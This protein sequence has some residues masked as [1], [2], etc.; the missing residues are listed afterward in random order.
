ML[1]E[2]KQAKSSRAA[3]LQA[4]YNKRTE[5]RAEALD[6]E[7]DFDALLRVEVEQL[8]TRYGSD[9]AEELA[10]RVLDEARRR[11]NDEDLPF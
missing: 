7:E 3:R 1:I 5:A 4:A 6:A 11:I 10:K 8:V 2:A 9:V